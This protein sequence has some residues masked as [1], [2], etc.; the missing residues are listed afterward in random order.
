M[1]GSNHFIVPLRDVTTSVTARVISQYT[2]VLTRE[3]NLL[4]VLI[5][6]FR[7]LTRVVSGSTNDVVTVTWS[8]TLRLE[9]E[10]A[11]TKETGNQE[12]ESK[13][14]YSMLIFFLSSSIFISGGQS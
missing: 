14:K 13:I 6:T 5:V 9:E 12:Y 10:E 2:S 7:L 4:H 1:L 8:A 11:Y 3:R